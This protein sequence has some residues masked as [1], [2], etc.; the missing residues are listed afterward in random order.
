[1]N[2]IVDA[3][4][5]IEDPDKLE[6]NHKISKHILG[7]PSELQD[8]FKALKALAD[9]C[10]EIEEERESEMHTME[11]MYEALYLDL[12]RQREEVING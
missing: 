7:M 12:Y 9:E 5:G 11:L 3:L 4:P 10:C 6:L 1:M 2:S 8:R